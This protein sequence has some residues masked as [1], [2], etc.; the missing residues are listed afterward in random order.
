MG[1]MEMPL[2]DNTL[3]MM[4]GSGPFGALGMGGMFSVV[5]VRDDVKPGDYRDPG[6]YRQPPGTLATEYVAEIEP[7]E[8][9]AA[10]RADAR[11][12]QVRK[13]GGHEGH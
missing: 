11:T 8:R 6:P 4:T 9:A 7:P 12:L 3:P 5:K 1:A 13:P 10:P 2:P